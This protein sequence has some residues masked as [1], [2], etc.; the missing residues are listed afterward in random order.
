MNVEWY[1]ALFCERR[2]LA[3]V[4]REMRII[5]SH[6]HY[7]QLCQQEKPCVIMGRCKWG[8]EATCWDCYWPEAIK[9]LKKP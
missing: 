4:I 5:K 7:C 1:A 2:R 9:E 6:V 3:I 8:Y